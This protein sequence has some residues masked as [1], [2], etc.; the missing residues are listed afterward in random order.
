MARDDLQK[1][2]NERHH[3]QQEL[4]EH[5]QHKA[6]AQGNLA[7]L[8]ASIEKTQQ[9][10][11]HITVE[12]GTKQEALHQ[13][14]R[15]VVEHH[16]EAESSQQ[17]VERVQADV[18][19]EENRLSRL[20]GGMTVEAEHLCSDVAMKRQELEEIGLQLIK[21]Q[22]Q[23]E[24]QQQSRKTITELQA[25]IKELESGKKERLEEKTKLV[26]AL[27]FSHSEINSFRKEKENVEK[28]LSETMSQLDEANDRLYQ[29]KQVTVNIEKT[30]G[31]CLGSKTDKQS[32]SK[33]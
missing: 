32:W 14:N 10:L 31:T 22:T 21:V 7:R 23:C 19:Q 18:E 25:Q 13:L 8:R 12:L 30:P 28:I 26:E 9:S 5:E 11:M 27:N 20:I 16:Q 17:H 29:A 1:V 2:K 33:R 6:E 4:Q 15:D 24:E 3:I